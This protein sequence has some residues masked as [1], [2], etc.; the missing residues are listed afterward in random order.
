MFILYDLIFVIFALIYLPVYLLKRKFHPGFS[1]RLGVLPP[2]LKLDRPIW[3][4][5]VS[6]GE[7]IAVKGLLEEIRSAFP[8]KR[9][10]ISTVTA[11]GNKIARSLAREQDFVTYLPLDLKFIVRRVIDRINPSLFII[12]ETEIWP[13]LI[14]Y[15]YGKKIPIII[16]NGRISDA[17]FKGYLAI[18]F[19]IGPIL[20][21]INIFSV[22]GARD[23]S[24][25]KELGVAQEKIKITG[26][27]KFDIKDYT[28]FKKDYTDLKNKLGL[29]PKDKLLVCGSTHPQEEEQ[30]LALYKQLH[31]HFPVLRLLIAP[32]H[33]ERSGEVAK[34]VSRCGWRS[35]AVSSLPA[36]CSTCLTNP[37]FI[38]DTV[39]QLISF[40][41]IAD[42]V[43]VGGSLTKNGGHN[44]LEPLS[45][46]KPVFFGPHMFNFRDIA[47]LFLEQGAAVQ[48]NNADQLKEKIKDFLVN[49]AQAE[50]LA[51]KAREI[52]SENSGAT[53]R[54]LELIKG[55]T[56]GNKG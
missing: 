10:V 17:S 11:T 48:V 38:L 40:Y 41:A 28:D 46:G 35:V 56:Y 3:C 9:L 14:S 32:R 26:N 55:L 42:I 5:A 51:A 44:I 4:H 6:V 8:E 24:R 19:L 43:F 27:M 52:I 21:K 45:L 20:N 49:P 18:K 37:V 7:V 39:G 31:R 16:V 29:K 34:I 36:A 13:N 47:E 33:P 23:A 12:A 15:L 2:E 25:F 1:R 50:H 22:Q 53:R 30:I 54:N